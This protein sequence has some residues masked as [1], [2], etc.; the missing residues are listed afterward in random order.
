MT[1]NGCQ[2]FNIAIDGINR[3]DYPDFVDAFVTSAEWDNGV[4]LTEGE[5]ADLTVVMHEGGAM[6]D[7]IMQR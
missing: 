4:S 6:F 7:R 1:L 3:R 5:C 2:V